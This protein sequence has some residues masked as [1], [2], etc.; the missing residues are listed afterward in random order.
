MLDACSGEQRQ[1]AERHQSSDG[2]CPLS[3]TSVLGTTNIPNHN[4]LSDTSSLVSKGLLSSAR[5]LG[6]T[7]T[8]NGGRSM[9]NTTLWAAVPMPFALS[10]T[11][12]SAFTSPPGPTSFCLPTRLCILFPRFYNAYLGA[13]AKSIAS[14]PSDRRRC[15]GGRGG[16]CDMKWRGAWQ[17]GERPDRQGRKYS[18]WEGSDSL[19]LLGDR[20][21]KGL[22]GRGNDMRAQQVN[23]IAS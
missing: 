7:N 9:R 15:G 22:D 16:S 12:P 11:V 18:D 14:P 19:E 8:E 17:S 5:C 13:W 2:S 20:Y 1:S 4:S 21:R 6:S 3:N 10:P 23:F